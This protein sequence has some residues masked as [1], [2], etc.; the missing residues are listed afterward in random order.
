MYWEITAILLK[1]AKST[2]KTRQCIFYV[3]L[4]YYLSNVLNAFVGEVRQEKQSAFTLAHQKIALKKMNKTW[5]HFKLK[6]MYR[7]IQS[8][9]KD[10]CGGRFKHMQNTDDMIDALLASMRQMRPMP[11]V[12]VNSQ[13][14]ALNDSPKP[15]EVHTSQASQQKT[16]V[17]MSDDVTG[18]LAEDVQSA[19]EMSDTT[20]TADMFEMQE[21]LK[22]IVKGCKTQCK[23]KPAKGKGKAMNNGKGKERQT[24]ASQIFPSDEGEDDL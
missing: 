21:D 2:L 13:E 16:P 15:L 17:A 7:K 12:P 5:N 14:A 4:A 3:S 22:K 9:G 18:T 20:C 11:C 1:L 6:M 10:M 19:H 23:S 24:L 8:Y